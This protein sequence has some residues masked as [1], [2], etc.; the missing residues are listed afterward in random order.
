MVFT[1]LYSFY[2]K[3]RH[4]ILQ[5]GDVLYYRLHFFTVV[6]LFICIIFCSI[7][8]VN[9]F[10]L[11]YNVSLKSC[12]AKGGEKCYILQESPNYFTIL[13]LMNPRLSL[14]LSNKN[15]NWTK[16][17]PVTWYRPQRKVGRGGQI[18]SLVNPL[19]H[20]WIFWFVMRGQ[21]RCMP[22]PLHNLYW[23]WY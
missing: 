10:A 13:L 23:K 15:N 11:M 4:I 20:G 3:S 5:I 16:N 21:G 22:T 7:L 8:I 17:G 9:Y 1:A 2:L 18:R 12:P 19:M 6:F 14:S